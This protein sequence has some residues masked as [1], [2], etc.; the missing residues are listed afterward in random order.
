M[1][2]NT[3]DRMSWGP[4]AASDLTLIDLERSTSRSYFKPLY[5]SEVQELGSM[6][7]KT[8]WKSYMLS[9]VTQ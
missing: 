3:S 4:T 7:T 9:P 1:L 2:L 8:Y 5:I 6:M